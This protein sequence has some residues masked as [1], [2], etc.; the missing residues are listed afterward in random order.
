MESLKEMLL[1][2]DTMILVMAILV[3]FI[4]YEIRSRTVPMRFFGNIRR[5]RTPLVYWLLILFHTVILGVVLY[6]WA[7][8]V[9]IPLRNLFD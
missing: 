7:D 9:R 1:S 2:L 5:D 6:A 3:V 8:G 4:A